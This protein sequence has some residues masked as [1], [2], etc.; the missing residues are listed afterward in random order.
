MKESCK[1]RII[2][3]IS[4]LIL[5]Q[6]FLFLLMIEKSINTVCL[7]NKPIWKDDDCQLTYCSD[8]DFESK[9]CIINN[10]II[11]TQW[12]NNIIEIGEKNFRFINIGIF[13]NG[14]MLI[15]LNANPAQSKRIFYGLKENGRPLF[16]KDGKQYP[17]YIKNVES[18]NADFLESESAIIKTIISDK[19]YYFSISR[20]NS[21]VEILSIEEDTIFYKSA[22]EFG[23]YEIISLRHSIF[24][25]ESTNRINDVTYFFCFVGEMESDREKVKRV[26]IE[27]HKFNQILTFGTV[28]TLVDETYE[29]NA[30]G[31]YVS[32]IQSPSYLLYCLYSTQFSEFIYFKLT[33][34]DNDFNNRVTFD[35]PSNIEDKNNFF[36]C[37]HFKDEVLVIAYYYTNGTQI[38]PIIWFKEFDPIYQTFSNF[39]TDGPYTNG[40]KLGIKIFCNDLLL[41]DFMKFND[42]TFFLATTLENKEALY[43]ISVD[44]DNNKKI[45][46][47]YY[48]IMTYELYHY[49]F[50]HDLRINQY[51]YY[52]V[53]ASSF[54]YTKICDLSSDYYSSLIIFSYPVHIDKE[55]K[56]EEYIVEKNI[57]NFEF[58]LN[59][60]M[61]IDNNIFGFVF[62]KTIINSV[63]L[64]NVNYKIYSSKY[65]AKEIKNDYI[66]EEDENI[67]IKY[68]GDLDYYDL[69]EAQIEFYYNM[70]EPELS[71]YDEYPE[72]IEG[73]SNVFFEQKMYKGR[74]NYYKIIL[75]QQITQSDC[76][77]PRCNLCFRHLNTKCL[78]CKY[79]SLVK[80]LNILLYRECF[81]NN[82]IL[83]DIIS[84]N[85][86]EE[87]T[88][89]IT[90]EATE[91]ITEEK[92]EKNTEM[93]TERNTEKNTE[94]VTESTLNEN[95]EKNTEMVTESTL[96]E[97]TEKNTEMVTES[98]SDEKTEKNT[99]MV[100]ES[101]SDEKTEKNTEIV[102]ES[103]LNEKTE[104]NTEIVTESTS[105]EKTE[106]NTEIVTEKATDS[107]L[108]E[109]TDQLTELNTE[110]FVNE[111]TQKNTETATDI[112]SDKKT[113]AITEMITNSVSDEKTEK[114][115]ELVTDIISEKKN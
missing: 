65:E 99:E 9:K 47:R 12:L 33:K 84:D 21:T 73:D 115:S 18:E 113:D 5:F 66:L 67:V 28:D 24:V 76:D 70:S 7:R 58:D 83:S 60:E 96:N 36:K 20:L 63:S 41:N 107:V 109:K 27:K 59:H 98:T 88:E 82:T 16:Q 85:N 108:N 6:I 74:V 77:D 95:T 32:C 25:D 104:K 48:S 56:L 50:L 26:F 89:K 62:V 75:T 90:E 14:D 79:V 94:I 10:P 31:L 86:V 92:T 46:I 37:V 97:N 29:P 8:S 19:E 53:L 30:Y 78:M 57:L 100:T 22:K 103:T 42:N 17:F 114:N 49:K 93:A 111:N 2:K 23:K 45:K 112:I 68:E 3:N 1:C 87:N 91:I 69:F 13:S 44:I 61:K 80:T 101:T 34:Y 81:D 11:K 110:S 40:I 105:D 71:I 15:H 35:F 38:M 72:S 55:V 51:G 52:L 39:L 102:T 54:C 64:N 43:I 4:S 106:K